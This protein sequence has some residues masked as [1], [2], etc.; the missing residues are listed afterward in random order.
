MSVKGQLL[1]SFLLMGRRAIQGVGEEE[2]GNNKDML[3][4]QRNGVAL[5]GWEAQTAAEHFLFWK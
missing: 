5:S 2:R 4:G 1:T 3:R